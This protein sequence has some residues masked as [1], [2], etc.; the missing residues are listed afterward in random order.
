MKR[1]LAIPAIV[2]FIALVAAGQ[3]EQGLQW[4]MKADLEKIVAESKLMGLDGAAMGSTVKGAPY[5]A[6]ETTESTQVLAD[7]TRIHNERQTKVFRDNEGRVR[8]ET[9]E[10]VTIWDPVAN[11]SYFLDPK[12]QSARKAMMRM[13]YLNTAK[14]TGPGGAPQTFEVRVRD[15]V[16]TATVNGQPVDPAELK[17]L[18]EQK[19]A[20]AIGAASGEAGAVAGVAGAM[21]GPPGAMIHMVPGEGVRYVAMQK[22]PP[23]KTESLGNQMIEGVNCQ[24]TRSVTEIETG[25]IG[26][27]RPIEITSERW[28]S[29]GLQTVVMTRRNDPRTGEE[30]FRLTNVIR[31]E[32]PA[33]L[34]QVPPTY[35]LQDRK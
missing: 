33:D 22:L 32:Q 29:P 5:S 18:Q 21:T 10:Q 9:P 1:W 30:I 14:T 2:P 24:G 20:G 26:N 3:Q 28:F 27:D 13:V 17:R 6:V 11:V 12:T 4:K 19:A 7:G 31:G 34:F 35:Q 25:A 15:G 8:R 23:P 16:T